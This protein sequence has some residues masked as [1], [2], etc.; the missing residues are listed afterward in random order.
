MA[1]RILLLEV[2]FIMRKCENL[3]VML[4]VK[5]YSRA[6]ILLVKDEN[7]LIYHL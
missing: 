4:Q 7:M 6:F 2:N 1:E 5:F 3:P